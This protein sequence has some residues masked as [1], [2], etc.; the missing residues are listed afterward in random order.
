MIKVLLRLLLVLL[1]IIICR[2]GCTTH[3]G[4]EVAALLSLPLTQRITVYTL[5]MDYLMISFP[6]H[7]LVWRKA[8]VLWFI[9]GVCQQENTFICFPWQTS[10]CWEA[11]WYQKISLCCAVREFYSVMKNYNFS[12]STRATVSKIQHILCVL[13]LVNCFL[14]QLFLILK[15]T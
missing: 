3:A 13:L 11:K 7:S 15:V 5:C 1:L 4:L 12:Q 2:F 6:V 8:Y 10:V 9:E 14:V